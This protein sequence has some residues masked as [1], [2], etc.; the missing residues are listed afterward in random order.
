LAVAL[1]ALLVG[2]CTVWAYSSIRPVVDEA[3]DFLAELAADDIAAAVTHTSSDDRCFGPSDATDDL[4]TLDVRFDLES[5]DLTGGSV[6]S[7]DDITTG[8]ASGT[9]T[10][11]GGKTSDVTVF[12]IKE[13]DMWKVCGL[14]YGSSAPVGGE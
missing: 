4:T 3:N 7:G 12:M 2:G 9:A 14:A 10:A 1:L 6:S 5:Y 11:V 8:A 13:D